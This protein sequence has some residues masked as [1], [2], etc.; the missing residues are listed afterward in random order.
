MSFSDKETAIIFL[1]LKDTGWFIWS[2][3][4]IAWKKLLFFMALVCGGKCIGVTI[5]KIK[6]ISA[7][8]LTIYQ[9]HHTDNRTSLPESLHIWLLQDVLISWEQFRCLNMGAY[10]PHG[11]CD[12]HDRLAHMWEGLRWLTPWFPQ[13]LEA[14]RSKMALDPQS[15][16]TPFCI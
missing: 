7:A 4:I 9:F 13:Q 15:Q 2:S 3:F 8:N 6:K 10:V 12:I 11:T 16:V 5:R 14:K 1:M